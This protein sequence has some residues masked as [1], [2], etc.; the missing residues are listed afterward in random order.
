MFDHL[1]QAVIGAEEILPEI[2]AALDKIFLILPIGDFAHAPDKQSVAIVLDER[3]PIA[4]PDAFD[5]VPTGAAEDGLEFLNDLAVAADGAVEPLQ[6]AVHNENQIVEPL[7]RGERDGAKRFGLVHHTVTQKR[8]DPAACR[9]LQPA[10]LEILDKARV[11]NRLN[12][13][14]AHRDCRKL[15]E[16][17]HQPRVRVRREPSARIQLAP[18]ILELLFWNAAFEIPT[19]VDTGGGVSLKI[20]DVAVSA[21]GGCLKKMIER[22][23]VERGRRG[24]R[25]NMSADAFLNLVGPDHHRERVPAH[26]ALDPALHFL[27]ARKRRLLVWRNRILIGGGGSEWQ[28]NAAGATRMQ[29]ELLEQ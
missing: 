16:V 14:Q 8:P 13:A 22:D 12:R 1:E 27:T 7:A 29:R 10:V 17:G 18:E 11:I 25:G 24:K 19:S 21:L 15:P 5:Y 3:I 9:S 23:F 28:V 20:D 2:S 4:A 26:Q 6:V